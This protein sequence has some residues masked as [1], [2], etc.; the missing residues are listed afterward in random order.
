MTFNEGGL[1]WGAFALSGD[2]QWLLETCMHELD[3]VVS[4]LVFYAQSNGTVISGRFDDV[5]RK[6]SFVMADK[7]T[8]WVVS[9]FKLLNMLQDFV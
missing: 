4:N 2:S 1:V 6:R 8:K 5:E 9:F 3:E 7:K